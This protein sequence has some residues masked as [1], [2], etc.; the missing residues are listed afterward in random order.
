MVQRQDQSVI[1]D[2][3]ISRIFP[4]GPYGD[5]LPNKHRDF[6]DSLPLHFPLTQINPS[7]SE[8][9]EVKVSSECEMYGKSGK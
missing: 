6:S 8:N 2:I 7:V 3:M 1:R 9:W 4:P 5:F